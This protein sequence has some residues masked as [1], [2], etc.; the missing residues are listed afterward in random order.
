MILTIGGICSYFVLMII[1]TLGDAYNHSI[2]CTLACAEGKGSGMKKHAECIFRCDLDMMTLVATRGRA[3]PMARL[4][5]RLRCPRCGSLRVRV[6]W[7]IP[8][9]VDQGKV[10]A[11]SVL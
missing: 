2:G 9:N 1:E 5:E 6:M 8:S 7:R 11:G 10:N 4:A 3:F